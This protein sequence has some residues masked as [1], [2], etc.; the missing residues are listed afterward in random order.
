MNPASCLLP[1][2]HNAPTSIPD[3][4]VQFFMLCLG[5]NINSSLNTEI[6]VIDTDK[7]YII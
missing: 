2:D 3:Y 5:K 7:L 1:T 6:S 4:A